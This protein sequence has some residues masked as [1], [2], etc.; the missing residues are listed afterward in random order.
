MSKYDGLQQEL[1]VK[2]VRADNARL[3]AAIEGFKCPHCDGKGALPWIEI[4]GRRHRC[5][6]CAPLIAALEGNAA[7][8]GGE[9]QRKMEELGI[10]EQDIAETMPPKPEDA[11]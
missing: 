10:T 2:A 4:D 5:K 8:E 9:R 1:M 11:R 7:G 6:T 3:R